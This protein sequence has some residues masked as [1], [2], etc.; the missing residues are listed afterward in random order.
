MC[1]NTLGNKAL[2]IL[3]EIWDK[4]FYT[5]QLLTKIKL[6]ICKLDF[7]VSWPLIK[8]RGLL[9]AYL[10]AWLSEGRI[11][12]HSVGFW[13][14]SVY[15]TSH[16]ELKTLHQMKSHKA[17][18]NR[19]RK[20]NRTASLFSLYETLCPLFV[21]DCTQH[22]REEWETGCKTGVRRIVS[23]INSNVPCHFSHYTSSSTAALFLFPN[24]YTLTLSPRYCV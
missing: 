1:A 20:Y 11:C 13:L 17:L 24:L 21:A 23:V 3:I 15:L 9:L 2:L 7:H 18:T 14:N 12:L 22:H 10:A 8:D 6:I 16:W 4:S 19:M 5:F